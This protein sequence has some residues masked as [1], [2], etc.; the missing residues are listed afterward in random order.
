MFWFTFL[1]SDIKIDIV[2][3]DDMMQTFEP[4]FQQKMPYR[5]NY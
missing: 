4:L 3:R 2:T 5:Q 1:F